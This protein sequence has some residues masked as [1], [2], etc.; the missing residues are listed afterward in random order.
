MRRTRLLAQ[1]NV[2][3]RPVFALAPSAGLPLA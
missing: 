2:D 1:K 3:F